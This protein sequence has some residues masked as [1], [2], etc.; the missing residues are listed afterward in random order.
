MARQKVT[1]DNLSD[2]VGD[3]LKDYADEVTEETKKSVH[4]VALAGVK[5][6]KSESQAKVKKTGKYAKGWRT[7]SKTTSDGQSEKLYNA[8]KPG[9]THLLE[10]GHAKRGGGRVQGIPHIST[11]E[12][13]LIEALPKELTENLSK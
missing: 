3:I 12:E 4:K 2:V 7:F 11:V 6:L 13:K 10:K 8:A 1:I 9:L 5:A